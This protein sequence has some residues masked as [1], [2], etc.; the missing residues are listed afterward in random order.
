MSTFVLLIA[1]SSTLALARPDS[2]D[3]V[4]KII[5]KGPY[6]N[7]NAYPNQDLDKPTTVYIQMYIEGMSSFRAQTMDFQVDIYFQEKWIDKRL[8]HN[9]TKRIL[10][11][12]PHLFKLI[13][14]PDIY[15]ANARTAEFHDVTQPNFLVWI[16]PNGTVWYDCRISLTVLCMQNLARYPLDS[17]SCA[18]RILSY[19]YDTD[20]I[21]IKWNGPD[22]IDV[23]P[24]IRMPDM[25]LR[26]IH[27]SIRNDTYATGIWSCALADFHVDREIMHHIIQSYLPTALIVVISWF[28]F[29]LDVEAVPGRV[30]LSITTLLTLATQSSAARMAL[31]QASYV[32][33][34][35]VWMGA[36]MTFVFSAMIEFTVVNYCTRRK[37]R[38]QEKTKGLS[39][40]VHNLVAQYKEKKGYQNGV[41]YE[42]SLCDNENSQENYEKKQLREMNQ[43][44][45][46]MRQNFLSN[47]KRKAIEERMNRVEENRKYAQSIDRRSRVY[48]P[49]A[50]ISFNVI[51]WIYYIKYAVDTIE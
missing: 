38:K 44:P 9:N 25:R 35:D 1:L 39:E 40:Q 5:A 49:L 51:Y 48:F 11:K 28:S 13:W 37:S 47:R 16:Y 42:V 29:W 27:P 30:S 36:C 10:L 7:R 41:C 32:K 34:I 19:A 24:E 6:Y 46:L 26:S 2:I 12:D 17:Q 50:F 18:L 45:V 20:E 21:V 22:P 3:D 23:N 33:A 43:T 4:R 31:P 15:F 14:H 8:A